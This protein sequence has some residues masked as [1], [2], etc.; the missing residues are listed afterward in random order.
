M[1][2]EIGNFNQVSNPIDWD[3]LESSGKNK[4]R[5]NFALENGEVWANLDNSTKKMN[6]DSSD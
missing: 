5:V 6:G 1:E 3:D 4:N 2:L